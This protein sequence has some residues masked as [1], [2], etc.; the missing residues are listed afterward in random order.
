MIDEHAYLV[1]NFMSYAS[2][3]PD[4]LSDTLVHAAW[5]RL[6]GPNPLALCVVS[7]PLHCVVVS[8]ILTC[9]LDTHYIL[10][11]PLKKENSYLSK[12]DHI[13]DLQ[14]C[15]WSFCSWGGFTQIN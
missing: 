10:A 11:F 8:N 5:C 9:F 15:T 1:H 6:F 2:M 14:N 13:I 12:K 4:G 3:R 7:I